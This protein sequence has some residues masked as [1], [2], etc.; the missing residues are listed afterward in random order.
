[1]KDFSALTIGILGIALLIFLG[2]FVLLC[3]LSLI[4]EATTIGAIP[5]TFGTWFGC[6][7]V[8]LMLKTSSK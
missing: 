1:M 6:L 5:L 8:I 2:P 3:G 7:L 4:A